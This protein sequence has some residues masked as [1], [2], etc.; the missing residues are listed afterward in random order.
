MQQFL[1]LFSYNKFFYV[2]KCSIILCFGSV[3]MTEHISVFRY[4]VS[5]NFGKLHRRMLKFGLVTK[6]ALGIFSIMSI[7]KMMCCVLVYFFLM[8][9]CDIFKTMKIL[10]VLYYLWLW[11]LIQL[12]FFYSFGIFLVKVDLDTKPVL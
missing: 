7:W 4:K 1:Y 2:F 6:F 9:G 11:V 3:T 5:K 12:D 8:R 10:D